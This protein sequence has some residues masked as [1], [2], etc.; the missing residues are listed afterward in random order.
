MSRRKPALAVVGATGAAGAVL[1]R[2]CRST[3][4]SGATSACSPPRAQPA[5]S[6]P[7]A[8]GDSRSSPWARTPSTG[9]DVAVF[10]VPEEVAAHWAPVA[11]ARGAVVVDASPAFRAHPDVPL[12]VPELNPDAAR[13]RPA[14]H[15]REPRLHHARPDRRGRR[16]ARPVRAG[17]AGRLRVPG[18]ERRGTGRRRR[19]AR[20]ARGGRRHGAGR[21]PRR[22]TQGPRRRPERTLPGPARAQRGPLVRHPAGGRLVLR[23]AARARRG[24]QGP[25]PAGAAGL[26]HLRAG[27]RGHRAL[28]RGARPLR[29]PL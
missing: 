6:W 26:R 2:S 3:P 16:A 23:G 1:L 20:P 10:L 18:G 9:V 21:G 29:T 11:A 4:T 25:R 5:A 28:R 27:P 17:R 7:C 15:R 13:E 22:R 8:G 12:V 19:P 24:P 14:R